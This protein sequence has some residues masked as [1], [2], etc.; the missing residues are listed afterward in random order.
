[1]R[2]QEPAA[3]LRLPV[4]VDYHMHLRDRDGNVEHT[5]GAARRFVETAAIRGVDEIGFAEHVYYFAQTRDIWTVPYQTERCRFDLDT[6]C[7]AVLEAKREGLPVKLGVE[8]DYV[9]DKQHHLTDILSPYPWDY[10]LGSVHWLGAESVDS[11]PGLWAH[12]AVEAVWRRYFDALQEL[13]GSG[14]V[15]ALAHPDLP[16]I[17]GRRPDAG[18]VAELHEEA[19][20]AISAAGVAIE[21]STAGLRKPVGEL[22]PDQPFLDACVR[23]GVGVTLASDAH[24]P[25]LVGEDFA[26]ALD[27]ARAAGCT[28]VT[29]FE[30]RESRQEPLG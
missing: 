27:A 18:A 11:Q 15:D 17:F 3:A 10:L 30:A 13:A 28:T 9:G 12:E 5:V 1:V 19:S 16:K 29:V 26:L 6:Y 24:E 14:A 7:N 22:Y 4:I 25:H 21:I 8:V 2:W 23:R 20:E